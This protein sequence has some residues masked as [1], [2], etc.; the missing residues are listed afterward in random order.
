M[1]FSAYKAVTD[2]NLYESLERAVKEDGSLDE[3]MNVKE[4]FGSWANQKGY[5]LLIVTRNY[6]DNTIQLTQ[7]RYFHKQKHH[8]ANLTSWWIPYNF[9]TA[10]NIAMHD[11][12]PDGWL[13]KEI[14][15]IIIKPT[16]HKNWTSNDWVLFNRQ[17]TGFYRIIYDEKNYQMILDDLKSGNGNKFHPNSKAQL[18][19]DMSNFMHSNRLSKYLYDKFQKYL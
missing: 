2:A 1:H 12:R 11:T 6:S 8:E 19:D 15:S 17:Q 10:N 13:T 9:D 5:P 14:K 16:E 4:I 3:E 7:E 18:E